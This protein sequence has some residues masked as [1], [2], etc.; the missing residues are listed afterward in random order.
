[1]PPKLFLPY[2]KMIL[3][4]TAKTQVPL[5]HQDVRGK[6]TAL[7][8]MT[9]CYQQMNQVDKWYRKESQKEIHVYRN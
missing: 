5:R 2:D 7:M 4:K 1:M 6:T 8:I 3:T 9:V